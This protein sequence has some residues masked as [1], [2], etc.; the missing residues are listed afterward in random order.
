MKKLLVVWKTT[1]EIKV[2]ACKM[3]ADNCG[4][5]E[6]LESLGV[7]VLY[8]GIYLSDNLKDPDTEVFTI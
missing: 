2:S 6:I 8:A 5:T 1:N 4:A 3:C 7:E